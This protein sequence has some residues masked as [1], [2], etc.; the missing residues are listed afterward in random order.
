MR[1][2][3][4]CHRQRNGRRNTAIGEMAI[5]F[6]TEG[7]VS[8]PVEVLAFYFS[9]I[10]ATNRCTVAKPSDLEWPSTFGTQSIRR[11]NGCTE[12]R[13]RYIFVTGGRQKRTRR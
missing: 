11:T 12:N 5:R 9:P 4:S 1:V 6:A 7:S 2:T 10:A 3:F 13:K 8:S